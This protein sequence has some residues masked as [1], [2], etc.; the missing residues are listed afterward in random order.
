LTEDKKVTFSKDE[1]IVKATLKDKELD[2]NTC[3]CFGITR[4]DILYEIKKQV[5]KDVVILKG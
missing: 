5:N 2:V 4:Q 3:Y 1:L